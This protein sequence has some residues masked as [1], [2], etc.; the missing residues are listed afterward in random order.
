MQHVLDK[1][2][3]CWHKACK[4][5]VAKLRDMQLLTLVF[6]FVKQP[7]QIHEGLV[8]NVFIVYTHPL[9]LATQKVGSVYGTSTAA[10]YG[11]KAL[12]VHKQLCLIATLSINQSIDMPYQ[13]SNKVD[14]GE[15]TLQNTSCVACIVPQLHA[16]SEHF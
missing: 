9:P 1:Q 13:G 16:A 5:L 2:Q 6:V 14:Q 8:C 7:A 4:N 12:P 3:V 11:I 15:V 10:I